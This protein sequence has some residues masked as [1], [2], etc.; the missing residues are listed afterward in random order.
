MELVINL[1]H[2]V[3]ISGCIACSLVMNAGIKEIF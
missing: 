1:L 3:G 2:V